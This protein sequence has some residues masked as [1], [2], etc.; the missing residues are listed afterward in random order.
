MGV[1]RALFGRC[2]LAPVE[3]LSDL[4]APLHNSAIG[5]LR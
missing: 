4:D 2:G 1:Y 5:T 3:T